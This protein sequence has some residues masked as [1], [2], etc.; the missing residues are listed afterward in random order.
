MPTTSRRAFCAT[1]CHAA[2]AVATVSARQ[3]S[4][5]PIVRGQAEGKHVSVT[6][7]ST[8]LDAVGGRVRVASNAGG[9]LVART[10]EQTFVALTGTC[11][12]ESCQVTDADSEA[13]V[14]PCHESRFDAK[15]EVLR[16]PAE[17][18]LE[19]YPTAFADGVLTITY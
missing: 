14:C 2:A 10:G 8:A 13:Y 12:H 1:V 3:T 5:L 15:G 9:F 7:A 19:Q 6:V 11:S 16:G 4:A 17:I 18:P